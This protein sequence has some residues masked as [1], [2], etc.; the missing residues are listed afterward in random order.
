MKNFTLLENIA[1]ELKLR[2]MSSFY[3]VPRD[4]HLRGAAKYTVPIFKANDLQLTKKIV[5]NKCMLTEI[6]KTFPKHL[7]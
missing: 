4:T 5:Y 3:N 2:S 6:S 1:E 7:N